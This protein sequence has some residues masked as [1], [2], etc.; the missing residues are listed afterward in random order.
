LR[1][2]D[3]WND[4]GATGKSIVQ[5]FIRDGGGYIGTCLGAVFATDKADFWGVP[6]G[7]DEFFLDLYSGVA[8]CG[9]EDIAPQGSW[10]LMTDVVVADRAHPVSEALPPRMRVVMYPNGP[11]LQPYP[12][13]RATIIATYDL[14]GNPAMVAFEY[15]DGRVFLSG[16]H[17]E[18]E[19]D[20]D[21]DGSAA[22]G[23]LADEGSEWP[24]LLA[25]MRW[26]VAP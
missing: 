24:L 16:P 12:D 2:P 25:V 5:R 8:H 17:P 4:L 19:V 13:T 20:S 3:P 22:F 26:I 23:D 15:G 11:Y 6:L 10:P 9:Q 21:R 14:T 7:V 18:I 1:D